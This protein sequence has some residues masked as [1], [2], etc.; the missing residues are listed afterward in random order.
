MDVKQ[1]EALIGLLRELQHRDSDLDYEICCI[2]YPGAG[3]YSVGHL[4]YTS[5]LDA[6]ISLVTKSLPGWGYRVGTCCVS[7]DAFIFP[8]YNSPQHGE[9][10]KRE[11]PVMINGVEWADYT[12]IDLRPSGRLPIAILVSLFTALKAIEAS[13]ETP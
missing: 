2:F 9:R 3:R 6:A 11:F 13:N 1:Y 7:D 8:D 4:P 10:L 5:S 12:D